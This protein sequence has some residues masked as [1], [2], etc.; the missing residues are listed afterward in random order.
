MA[1]KTGIQWC[2]ST[3]NLQMGC[4]GCEL[5]GERNQP[6]TCYAGAITLAINDQGGNP[7]FPSVFNHPVIYPE[8]AKYIQEWSDLT[9]KDRNDK[10][11]L[12]GYP[13][14]IFLNDMGDTFTKELDLHW[15]DEFIP[16]MEESPHI[17]LM[18]TKRV[19]RMTTFWQEYG[20]VPNNIW[21][22]TTVTKNM[23]LNRAR[24]LMTI[25]AATHFVSF[26]PLLESVELRDVRPEW[27]IVGFESGRQS[28]EGSP[29]WMRR[30]RDECSEREIPYFVKQMGGW[31]DH[32]GRM[33]DIPED[34]RIR[35]VPK[36]N[37]LSWKGKT[38]PSFKQV[39]F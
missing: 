17:Y 6:N 19:R 37:H 25:P 14:M 2:D 26:E 13:R 4:D 3:L 28:R 33:E 20:R 7:H 18:L 29:L 35:D 15:L 22:G 12:S 39:S 8:R 16:Q 5:W 32:K 34:L 11:W 21:L 1:N 23:N 36:W 9:G 24:E 27:V 31:S 38:P 30:L 10:P